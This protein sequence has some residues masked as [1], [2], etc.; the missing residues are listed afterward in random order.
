[1]LSPKSLQA[2][3]QGPGSNLGIVD[4]EYSCSPAFPCLFQRAKRGSMC[5]PHPSR[6]LGDPLWWRHD[7]ETVMTPSRK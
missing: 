7:A 6:S 5:S 1:M 4:L 2:G 3:F